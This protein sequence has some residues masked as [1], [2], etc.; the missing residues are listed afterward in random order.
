MMN[1]SNTLNKNHI[2]EDDNSELR[3]FPSIRQRI[4]KRVKISSIAKT[5]QNENCHLASIDLFAVDYRPNKIKE[6]FSYQPSMRAEKSSQYVNFI[7]S[8]EDVFTVLKLGNSEEEFV[9]SYDGA[10]D[11]LAE[12]NEETLTKAFYVA[13]KHYVSR[14]TEDV[15]KSWEKNWDILIQALTC[16]LNIEPIKKISLILTLCDRRNK[17][18]RRIKLALIDAI[19][20]IEIDE[21]LSN[22]LLNLFISDKYESDDVVRQKAQERKIFRSK[23][24]KRAL[25]LLEEWKKEGD[26]VEQTETAEFLSEALN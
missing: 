21:N 16:S 25:K 9:D 17:L 15:A 8:T 1:N 26:E 10:V 23:N 3:N 24:N 22:S 18:S 7:Q 13:K 4:C 19:I 11:L 20:N 2:F 12:C 6:Y 14:D 5:K